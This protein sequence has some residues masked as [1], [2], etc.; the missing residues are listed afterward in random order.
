[1]QSFDRLYSVTKHLSLVKW[2]KQVQLLPSHT[3]TALRFHLELG[4]RETAKI[5]SIFLFEWWIPDVT[6][7][8]GDN[9]LVNR[10]KINKYTSTQNGC[11]CLYDKCYLLLLPLYPS[12]HQQEGFLRCWV[13]LP[14]KGRFPCRCCLPRNQALV[15]SKAI[16]I[17]T[18]AA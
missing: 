18:N 17:D 16:W 14:V 6:F 10:Q 1:M 4:E 2:M 9:S 15:F 3:W 8:V 11:F 13:L 7:A 5:P 12:S